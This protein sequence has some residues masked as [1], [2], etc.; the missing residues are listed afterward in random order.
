M[1]KFEIPETIEIPFDTLTREQRHAITLIAEGKGF[2]NPLTVIIDESVEICQ[3]EI[4]ILTSMFDLVLEDGVAW[5]GTNAF[6][7]DGHYP[8][9]HTTQEAIDA[10]PT[11][12]YIRDG[13]TTAGYHTHTINGVDYYMP[14]G[15]GGAGSGIQFHGTY[16]VT[17]DAIEELEEELE[18][19]IYEEQGTFDPLMEEG[20]VINNT[21]S[22][23][24]ISIPVELNGATGWC[25]VV[26]KCY[27]YT[28]LD[29][30]MTGG[31]Y[32]GSGSTC[33]VM[34][35]TFG[36]DGSTI[37]Y[38]CEPEQIPIPPEE[39]FVRYGDEGE[40]PYYVSGVEDTGN[41]VEYPQSFV[42]EGPT[43]ESYTLYQGPIPSPEHDN[44]PTISE[45][46][47]LTKNQADEVI[48]LLETLV[49]TLN[50]LK[51][52]TDVISGKN[53]ETMDDFFDRLTI[54]GAYSSIMKTITD[55][56]QESYSF[57]FGSL[58]GIGDFRLN[59]I[60]NKT[61]C[62]P[63]DS[64]DSTS[65]SEGSGIIGLALELWN[66]PTVFD[67]VVSPFLPKIIEDV[68]SLIDKDE[69]NYCKAKK[70]VHNYTLG[71]NILKETEN[72]PIFKEL[73][74]EIF[75]TSEF[76]QK[77]IDIQNGVTRSTDVFFPEFKHIERK[78]TATMEEL[79]VS[80]YPEPGSPC[81]CYD[82][83]NDAIELRRY[84]NKV[85]SSFEKSDNISCDAGL[86]ET[87]FLPG[88]VGYPGN[89]GSIGNFGV[90]GPAGYCDYEQCDQAPL[91]L[92]ACCLP[93]TSCESMA[94]D[95]CIETTHDQCLFYGGE[96]KGDNAT[97]D[98]THCGACTEN[99]HCVLRGEICCDGICKPPP[100]P[101]CDTSSDC[102]G[103]DLCCVNGICEYCPPPLCVPPC[104][105]E[106]ECCDDG[107]CC[108]QCCGNTCCPSDAECCGDM[109]CTA[110]SQC[111]GGGCCPDTQDCCGDICCEDMYYCCSGECCPDHF[112]C[113]GDDCCPPEEAAESECCG[114]RC[115]CNLETS[116]GCC[117]DRSCCSL[118][119][120]CCEP[121]SGLIRAE[122]CN[123]ND[124]CWP[125][126]GCCPDN[127]IC[128]ADVNTPG[129]CCGTVDEAECCNFQCCPFDTAF[130]FSYDGP[131]GPYPNEKCCP[132]NDDGTMP[133]LSPPCGDDVC[134]CPKI[135][136]PCT[137]EEQQT[138]CCGG[139]CSL[140]CCGTS[141]NPVGSDYGCC[142]HIAPAD[143]YC[144]DG[145]VRGYRRPLL[146][147]PVGLDPQGNGD[148]PGCPCDCLSVQAQIKDLC[149]G[150]GGYVWAYTAGGVMGANGK[151]D[152]D[153]RYYCQANNEWNGC[154][155][156]YSVDG[157]VTVT[158]SC[159]ENP[160]ANL[161]CNT[162][163]IVPCGVQIGDGGQ[164]GYNLPT[165]LCKDFECRDNENPCIEPNC[166]ICPCDDMDCCDDACVCLGC[167]RCIECGENLNGDCID[168]CH[169]EYG[170]PCQSFDGS[171]PCDR[172]TDA[173]CS[174][175]GNPLSP[176]RSINDILGTDAEL[177][178]DIPIVPDPV[179]LVQADVNFQIVNFHTNEKIK[180]YDFTEP[181]TN[182]SF[183]YSRAE[184][185][186]SKELGKPNFESA[187]S[188]TQIIKGSL[189]ASISSDGFI[190]NSGIITFVAG[191]N[192]KLD[193][194][195]AK[196]I[197][198]ISVDDLYLNEIV[199][200]SDDI[201]GAVDG[202]TLVYTDNN[203]WEI[204]TTPPVGPTGPAPTPNDDSD[205]VHKIIYN[206]N[207]TI[208]GT[209]DFTFDVNY[210]LVGI[211][212]SVNFN[213]D[214]QI[215]AWYNIGEVFGSIQDNTIHEATLKDTSIAVN[216]P[217]S[218]NIFMNFEDGNA[219]LSEYSVPQFPPNCAIWLYNAPDS[220][221][222]GTLTMYVE[223]GASIT[224]DDC[225]FCNGCAAVGNTDTIMWAGGIEPTFSNRLDIV[226]FL[227]VD[228]GSTYYGF[229]GGQDFS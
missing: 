215:G 182:F 195:E 104:P 99:I 25:C 191:S 138:S 128:C 160:C 119:E 169:H 150:G 179:E 26:N 114:D 16:G 65:I 92:G 198:R 34:G 201:S 5:P 108:P 205:S 166:C 75:S 199:D 218:G 110:G 69:E 140:Y 153:W 35:E 174:G 13:E 171:C 1:A 178:K 90:P 62:V 189:T 132:K 12:D 39:D 54:A 192:I 113:C 228:G 38:I 56:D 64:C 52:H 82:C 146:G 121:E 208:G 163:F 42:P 32:G 175:G 10:S 61:A 200:V 177:S 79:L 172:L 85:F 193:T 155:S 225:L 2:Q 137:G 63:C 159:C 136:N 142:Q 180:L 89:E 60:I 74:S 111:C 168:Y 162:T 141:D 216:T 87:T 123:E 93:S 219:H 48:S 186:D 203:K 221:T 47:P 76:K 129:P 147:C 71:Q 22:E 80:P 97:C 185:I 133:P 6:A 127:W 94:I 184:L 9:F 83:E 58:M 224:Y 78:S 98:I 194:N 176:P 81:D 68:R 120:F 112:Y 144:E 217:A 210:N 100:C 204:A 88:P 105:P 14:N 7:L 151:L 124:N 31:V 84:Q 148:G 229:V 117:D 46:F 41:V 36:S 170:Y 86:S 130:C 40:T 173:D 96:Y 29:C 27:S 213:N 24:D 214:I 165:Y 66:N 145:E 43:A 70:V 37:Y 143:E 161:E 212:A 139:K 73:V 3:K 197:I 125:S 28:E 33:G 118:A 164:C 181:L 188:T 220:G 222:V 115:P 152:C 95:A 211:T 55:I 196:N 206:E 131:P 157:N 154:S 101:E 126:C 122:C 44:I 158:C 223:N 183:K 23:S 20:G 107:S 57:V 109:C 149:P 207:G 116:S 102:V 187:V 18:N 67:S 19:V 91:I 50:M 156:E 49:M 103:T 167:Q 17:S 190:G 135:Y 72:D 21:E 209:S 4:E 106:T 77:L 226:T 51:F 227:T 30:S 11:P 59:K 8:L 45:I 202:D 134:P 53:A 15:L